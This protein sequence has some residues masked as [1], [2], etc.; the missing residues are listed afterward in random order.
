MSCVA[1]FIGRYFFWGSCCNDGSTTDTA[2]RSQI[3]DMVCRL[4]NI[5][6]CSMTR[7]VFPIVNKASQDFKQASDVLCMKPCR[8]LIQNIEGFSCRAFVEFI[9]QLHT[10][11]FSSRKGGSRLP[12]ALQPSPTSLMV[13]S[14]LNLGNVLEEFHGIVDGHVQDLRDILFPYSGLLGFH[15]CSESVANFTSHVN[16]GKKCISI[17]MIPSPEQA[18][19]RPPLTLKLKRPFL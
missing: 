8:W 15:C 11:S 9:S 2:L 18:S 6:L 7:T 13:W 5:R 4:D 19:Q 14:L 17:L 16:I 12:L 3:D 1:G 10:L